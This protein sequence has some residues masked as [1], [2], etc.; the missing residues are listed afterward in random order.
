MLLI[1]ISGS[2]FSCPGVKIQN[3]R[4]TNSIHAQFWGP[5]FN[6]THAQVFDSH[7]TFSYV[8]IRGL[9]CALGVSGV[10]TLYYILSKFYSKEN[11]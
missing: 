10:C 2:N 5:H 9:N 7:S 11:H 1:N 3:L 4:V 8:Q 6:S